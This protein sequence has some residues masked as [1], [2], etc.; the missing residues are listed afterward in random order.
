MWAERVAAEEWKKQ[1]L[2]HGQS[3]DGGRLSRW[4]GTG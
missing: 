1:A 3:D 2:E 4:N